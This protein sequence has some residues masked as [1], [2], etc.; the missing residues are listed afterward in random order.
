MAWGNNGNVPHEQQMESPVG[1]YRLKVTDVNN[2]DANQPAIHAINS[3]AGANALALLVEGVSKLEGK[4]QITGI[5]EVGD[6]IWALG[7]GRIT[8]GDEVY[9]DGPVLLEAG[10]ESEGHFRFK[11]DVVMWSKLNVGPGDDA[12]QINAMEGPGPTPRN[13]EIGT[14]NATKDVVLS[15]A[16]RFVDIKGKTRLNGNELILNDAGS[17]LDANGLGIVKGSSGPGG[18]LSHDFYVDGVLVYIIDSNGGRN[19]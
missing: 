19:A 3:N 18:S 8:F 9:F 14:L 7:G 6:K 13:I 15:R 12:G 5:L 1:N 10:G 17:V 11:E 16:E 4:T 2:N